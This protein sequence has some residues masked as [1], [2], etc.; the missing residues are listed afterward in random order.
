[1]TP[2][3]AF[4]LSIFLAFCLV[5][6]APGVAWAKNRA[7][8]GHGAKAEEAG[9]KPGKKAAKKTRKG[10][11]NKAEEGES[12]AASPKPVVEDPKHMLSRAKQQ[13]A[14]GDISGCFQTLLKF[15]NV[16]PRHPERGAMLQ[17]LAQ[18]AQQK[19]QVDKALQIYSLEA[20]LYPGTKAAAAAKWQVQTLEFLQNLRQRDPVVCLKGYLQQL[21]SLAPAVDREKLKE[22][23]RQ[24]WQAV[25]RVLRRCSPC[26]VNLVEEALILWDLHPK[27]TQ[28]PEAALL[29]GEL[30]Q[31]KGLYGEARYYLQR[32]RQQGTPAV[33]TRALVGLLEGAWDAR[34]LP[35]FA[36]AWSLWRREKREITP[37]LK[38]RLAKL[39]LPEAFFSQAAAAGPDQKPEADAVAALL[40]WWSGKAPAATQQADLLQCLGHFLSQPLPSAVKERLLMQLAQLQWSQGHYPQAAKIYQSLLAANVQGENAAFYQDRL[41]LSQ[42]QERRPQEAVQIYRELSQEGDKFWQLVSRTRLADVELGR[43]QMEPPQ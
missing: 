35:E 41:A 32:A 5:S 42:L 40:N 10:K 26:P 39:P 18:L 16:Y 3:R 23:L 34:D 30:L 21:Q 22:P 31:E 13:E 15:V 33:R 27:G 19:G 38:S 8:R 24:G 6:A 29:V 25:G 37:E 17:K 12:A 28:P 36:A 4:W 11:K 43:L 2:F 7:R 14:G 1:M 20:N 9:A